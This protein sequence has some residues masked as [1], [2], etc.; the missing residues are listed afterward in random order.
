MAAQDDD[1][2]GMTVINE[3]TDTGDQIN[4]FQFKLVSGG[5]VDNADLLDDIANMVTQIYTII[6]SMIN[7]RNILKAVDVINI[8]QAL[9]VGSTDGGSYVGGTSPDPAL[10]QGVSAYTYYK[11]DV[12]RVI[13]SKYWPSPSENDTAANGRLTTLAADDL[14]D[15][16]IKLMD[17]I[18]SLTGTYRYGFLSPK[19]LGFVIPTLAVATNVLA[20]QRRR[21]LGRGS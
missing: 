21:K 16:N 3:N 5:P 12:P 11:T 2:I 14:D 9:I 4:R 13:L 20:Y 10:P 8:T 17:D 1:I 6:Q 19:T 15:V 18:V 7:V